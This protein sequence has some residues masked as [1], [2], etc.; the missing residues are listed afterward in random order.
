MNTSKMQSRK[1]GGV[2]KGNA[3]KEMRDGVWLDVCPARLAER[4]G[5]E[6]KSYGAPKCKGFINN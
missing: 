3:E 4:E 5:R 6:Q 1:G 2:E